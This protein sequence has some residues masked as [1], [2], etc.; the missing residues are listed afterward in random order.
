MLD[1][2]R[3]RWLLAVGAAVLVGVGFTALFSRALQ[4]P[5]ETGGKEAAATWKARTGVDLAALPRLHP[6]HRDSEE[7]RALDKLLE[8]IDLHLCGRSADRRRPPAG[9][10]SA[11]DSV[12]DLREF[13]RDA[14]RA[15][16]MEPEALP[17]AAVAYVERRA[18]TLD[19]VAEYVAGHRDIHWREDYEPR[20][21]PSVLYT[22]DH[23]TFHRLLIGR[24]FRALERGDAATAARMLA[25]SRQLSAALEERWELESQSIAI[26]AE[27]LQLALMRRAGSA[28]SVA[29]A[30]P[31]RGTRERYLAATSAEAA[32]VLASSQ[33]SGFRGPDDDPAER[34]VHTLA[35]P[36]IQV[37]ASEAVTLAAAAVDEIRRSPDG[38]AELA[39][40]RPRPRGMFADNFHTL[41]ATEAWRRFQV[42]ELDR[43][44]TAAVLT[45]RAASPCPSVIITVRDDGTTRTVESKGLPA[46]SESIIDLP[47]IVTV[48]LKR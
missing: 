47:E 6:P 10:P 32:L 42:L 24:A 15:D 11:S 19:A 33:Q 1:S 3:N 26:G 14:I 48:R 4:P 40:K 12:E 23:L 29:P 5:E 36:K 9:E 28:L 37:A 35:A 38:C 41:N 7:A 21:R 31:A 25:T 30:E 46:R 17:P 2:V 8:P 20:P 39:K 43:A 45:G 22:R 27:R 34:V 18:A 44:I 16:S 13:L